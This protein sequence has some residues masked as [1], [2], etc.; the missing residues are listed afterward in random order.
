MLYATLKLLHILSLIVWLGGM[1]FSLFCLRPAAAQLE[2]A[3]KLQLMHGALGRFFRVAMWC[4]TVV[5]GSGFWM[6]GRVA[7]QTVQAGGTF[8]MPLSWTIMAALGVLMVLVLG[9]IR[10][11]LYKRL[12]R[13]VAA[14]DWAAG[15]KAMDTIKRWVSIN[16]AIGVAIVAIV[17]LA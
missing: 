15:A 17:L 2:P 8:A 4:A 5:L 13:A 14:Q 10:F 12:D 3:A 16:L 9:H 7:K 6:M 11:A 1:V